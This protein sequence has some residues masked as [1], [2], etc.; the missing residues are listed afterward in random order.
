MRLFIDL[1]TLTLIAGP[2]DR[3]IVSQI[4]AK[5]GDNLPIELQFLRNG[6]PVR[7][8]ASTVVTFG[9]KPLD[10]FDADPIVLDSTFAQSAAPVDP[11][12]PDN[13]VWT[14]SPSLNSVE[15]NALFL[16]DGDPYNDPRFIDLMAEF[17]WLASG[18]DGPTSI[19]TITF[20]VANDVVRGD[21][22]TPTHLPSPDDYV[23]ARAVLY[24]RAQTLTTGQREI[25]RG[26]VFPVI[27]GQAASG[28]MGAGNAAI[29]ATAKTAGVAGNALTA[30]VVIEE[31]SVSLDVQT[32]NNV[33][34][35]IT[36]GD[37][38]TMVI[39]HDGETFILTPSGETFEANGITWPAWTTG[40]TPYSE[41]SGPGTARLRAE[42]SGWAWDGQNTNGVLF[43]E[44][45]PSIPGVPPSGFPDE[46]NSADWTAAPATAAQAIALSQSA[47]SV[48]LTLAPGS[49]GSASLAPV[50]AT[51][52]ADG[53]DDTP[54]PTLPISAGGTGATTA[55][56][57]RANLGV[58]AAES[59][60]SEDA[61][62][63]TLVMRDASGSGTFG[64]IKIMEGGME[65]TGSNGVT[66]DLVADG[67]SNPASLSFPDASGTIALD[68]TAAMLTGNQTIA[69]QKTF[70]TAPRSTGTP[71][72][73]TSILNRE[74]GD[75]RYLASSEA[76]SANTPNAIVR[77]SGNGSIV[78]QDVQSHVLSLQ[79]TG[80][81][82]Y[83]SILPPSGSDNRVI[84]FPDADGTIALGPATVINEEDNE[85]ALTV[86]THAGN[87]LVVQAAAGVELRLD[88]GLSWPEDVI[89]YVRRDSAC[90]PITFSTA[91]SF[92]A[93]T[94]NAVDEID[95][96]GT[97]AIRRRGNTSHWD[98]L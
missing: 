91:G 88:P 70:S 56:G 67:L 39:V 94:G 38:H 97:F 37:K 46:Q 87:F 77:R 26:N 4:R 76:S 50:A 6:Q 2:N 16:I 62:P 21:E 24:D 65:I 69:G 54:N 85:V 31:D 66:G 25:G 9:A 90:G 15:L 95:Q 43:V 12:E 19:R 32:I 74:Q 60:S 96:N 61:T 14:A 58:A 34:T 68:S 89:I 18:D 42:L 51:S 48:A 86:A 93:P 63:N 11:E 5:R 52:L 98:F 55:A 78:V 36:A 83:Y 64:G 44:S 79:S 13:P 3:R 59:E 28:V 53:I 72:D 7:L 47:L 23:A 71:D 41:T 92:I 35:V 82:F 30:E 73:D 75:A 80:T 17:T 33:N 8:D 49:D 20:R 40:G 84:Y 45:A 29:Q 1:D 22:G 81:G 10:K 57:A 27:P